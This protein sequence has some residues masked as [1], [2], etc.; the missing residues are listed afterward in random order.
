M[1]ILKSKDISRMLNKEIEEKI[2]NLNMELIKERVNLSKGGKMKI[3]EI[4]K[5]I[6]KLKTFNRLNS[7]NEKPVEK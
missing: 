4:K 7:K 5:T 2:K 1:V 3:K 6:A